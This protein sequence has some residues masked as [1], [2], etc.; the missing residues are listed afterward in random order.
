MVSAAAILALLVFITERQS[1]ERRI[2]L[3]PSSTPIGNSRSHYLRGRDYGVWMRKIEMTNQFVCA[4]ATWQAALEAKSAA[5]IG[6]RHRTE[7]VYVRWEKAMR[8]EA[9]A[10][11][12]FYEAAA[13]L[14][15]HLSSEA[16]QQFAGR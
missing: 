16:P 15:R 5:D 14:A 9:S 10:R 11:R 12:A 7:D 1:D 6:D 2:F 3:R 13:R 8:L 4:Y